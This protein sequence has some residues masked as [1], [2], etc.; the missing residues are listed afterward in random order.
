MYQVPE[1][2]CYVTVLMMR[3]LSQQLRVLEI[4]GQ[5]ERYLQV[6]KLVRELK[7]SFSGFF[8]GLVLHSFYCADGFKRIKCITAEL[9]LNE[10]ICSSQLHVA[11]LV[12]ISLSTI[13]VSSC[14]VLYLSCAKASLI[15]ISVELAL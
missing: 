2:A 15:V 1:K 4:D 13:A 7:L 10:K 6:N 11:M 8:C 5:K 12:V 14:V 9:P 3:M